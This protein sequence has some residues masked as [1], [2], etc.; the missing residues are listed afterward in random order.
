MKIGDLVTHV[1][2]VCTGVGVVVDVYPN[3][4]TCGIVWPDWGLEPFIHPQ[5]VL[6]VVSESR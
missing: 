2:E 6:E 1:N 4:N 3:H 5:D